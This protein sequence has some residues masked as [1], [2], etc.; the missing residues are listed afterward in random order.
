MESFNQNLNNNIMN[1][2]VNYKINVF[3]RFSFRIL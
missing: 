2:N 1:A 3:Y